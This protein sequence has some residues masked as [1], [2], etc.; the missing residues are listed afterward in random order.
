[1]HNPLITQE[2]RDNLA[3]LSTYLR[4][5]ASQDSRLK[6]GM[7]TF[8]SSNPHL[9]GTSACA[10]G[11][12][13]LMLGWEPVNGGV[14]P[15]AKQGLENCPA[16]RGEVLGWLTFS[17]QVLGLSSRGATEHDWNW[18]FSGEWGEVDNTILG[19]AARIDYYLERGVPENFSMSNSNSKFNDTMTNHYLDRRMKLEAAP[20][21]HLLVE[22]LQLDPRIAD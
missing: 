14:T 12:Y 15:P 18:M 4:E 22:T 11:H 21:A 9:C 5:K 17:R 8:Y 6:F 20:R 3:K 16:D 7:E 2:T 10:I 13:A 19:A 1:M